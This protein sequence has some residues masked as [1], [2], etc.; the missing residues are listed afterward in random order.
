MSLISRLKRINLSPCLRISTHF[1]FSIPRPALRPFFYHCQSISPGCRG[2]IAHLR[3]TIAYC[4]RILGEKISPGIIETKR[5]IWSGQHVSGTP[6]G[7]RHDTR[8]VEAWHRVGGGGINIVIVDDISGRQS[9]DVELVIVTGW[10]IG[11]PT[12]LFLWYKDLHWLAGMDG[13]TEYKFIYN[14]W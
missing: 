5:P 10:K 9:F 2:K 14:V 11:M 12:A 13:W 8:W 3:I 7:W 4:M 1:S 6:G